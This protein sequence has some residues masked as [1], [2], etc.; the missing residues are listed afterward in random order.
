MVVDESWILEAL[1]RFQL[2]RPFTGSYAG[3]ACHGLENRW[4]AK[5]VRV[6]FYYLPAKFYL[7]S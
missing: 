1:V 5:V 6:R 4:T 7:V 2:P 3:W